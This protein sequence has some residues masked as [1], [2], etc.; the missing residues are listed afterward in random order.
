MPTLAVLILTFN[1]EKNIKDC[2]SSIPF[3]DEIIVVD[4][5]SADNT[6]SIAQSL[7]AKVF[8]KAMDQGFAAQR[9]FALEQTQAEWVLFLDADERITPELAKEIRCIVDN[10]KTG[11][12][13]ILR[14]NIIF[15]KMINH[16]AHK[17]DWCLRLCPRKAVKWEGLVHESAEVSE[18]L[19]KCSKSMLHYTYTS[20]E[21]YFEK[22][23]KYTT[24]MAQKNIQKGKKAGFLDVLLRP[25][26]GFIRMYF[27]RLGF[28]DGKL[29]FILSVLHGYYTFVKYIKLDKLLKDR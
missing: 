26:Y 21:Q 17:P 19:K 9:N 18:P 24:L 5:L 12:Y 27:L 14:E 1:E 11:A 3:A 28:L 23:N 8:S 6:V 29:G 20:W 16:G 25:I 10:N 7:G 2:I 22:M 15:G 13:K 4:S